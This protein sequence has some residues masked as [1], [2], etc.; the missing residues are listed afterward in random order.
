MKA[1]AERLEVS[2]ATIYALVASGRLHCHATAI[3]SERRL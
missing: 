3:V 1:V 2:Q